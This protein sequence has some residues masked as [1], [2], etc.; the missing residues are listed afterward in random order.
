MCLKE[1]HGRVGLSVPWLFNSLEQLDIFGLDIYV[2]VSV[3]VRV[4]ACV[5]L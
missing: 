4:C 2:S 5:S 3:C 1:K